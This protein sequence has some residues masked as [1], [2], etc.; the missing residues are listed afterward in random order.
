MCNSLFTDLQMFSCSLAN[1][2]WG[3]LA[4]SHLPVW[5]CWVS[6]VAG[7]RHAAFATVDF[8]MLV[9]PVA[10]PEVLWPAV[11]LVSNT[12][13]LPYLPG[14]PTWGVLV[15]TQVWK[16]ESHGCKQKLIQTQGSLQWSSILLV[17]RA[18]MSIAPSNLHQ[19]CMHVSGPLHPFLHG[20]PHAW[21]TL[22]HPDA[23]ISLLLVCHLIA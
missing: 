7:L 1:S 2:A 23:F 21:S 22:T 5:A 4:L 19:T 11:F 13:L 18:L 17:F 9:F 6:P 10:D 8:W 3:L 12:N 20:Y 15:F 14:S 16:K